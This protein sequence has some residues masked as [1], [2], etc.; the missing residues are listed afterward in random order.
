MLQFCVIQHGAEWTVETETRVL[1][2]YTDRVNA[3]GAAI[4]FADREGKAGRAAQ[5]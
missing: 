3:I 4:D 1:G 5:W 2:H